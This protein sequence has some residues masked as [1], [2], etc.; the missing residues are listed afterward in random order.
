VPYEFPRA[1]F[2]RAGW[3]DF[4]PRQPCYDR[5]WRDSHDDRYLTA[6]VTS[7]VLVRFDHLC[8][9]CGRCERLSSAEAYEAGWDY[10]PNVGA[11]TMVSPR[12]CPKCP[13]NE[14]LW[15]AVAVEGRRTP[16]AIGA[17]HVKTLERIVAEPPAEITSSSG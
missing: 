1:F 3:V 15:W 5:K 14:T 6:D 4:V 10:P 9:V 7:E 13:I 17:R 16:E 8:E 11:W 2:L 12:T